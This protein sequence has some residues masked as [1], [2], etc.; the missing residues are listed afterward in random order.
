MVPAAF[1]I[2]NPNA[3]ELATVFVDETTPAIQYWR[4]GRV[5][6]TTI[7]TGTSNPET[8]GFATEVPSPATLR[9]AGWV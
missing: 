7:V 3:R 1:L 8:T 6:F 2:P 9:T 4:T 5:K